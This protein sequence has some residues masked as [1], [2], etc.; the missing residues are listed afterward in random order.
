MA[1]LVT[2]LPPDEEFTPGHWKG[3]STDDFV[4]TQ[5]E[6]SEPKSA[7]NKLDKLR[8][9]WHPDKVQLKDKHRIP[10]NSFQKARHHVGSTP[11][12]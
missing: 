11:F 6:P 4:L 12:H 9:T 10:D 7:Y 8:L 5:L 1:D 2:A 3:T